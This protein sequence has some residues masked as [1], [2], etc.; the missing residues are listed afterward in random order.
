LLSREAVDWNFGR[1]EAIIGENGADQGEVGGLLR[2][3]QGRCLAEAKL[4]SD[5]ADQRKVLFVLRNE[6]IRI[7]VTL[8]D[9]KGAILKVIA[10]FK[11]SRRGSRDLGIHI[12]ASQQLRR[13]Q[14]EKSPSKRFHLQR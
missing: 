5:A 13:D 14:P 10:T 12:D 9:V 6:A 3:R 2:S 7:Q 4:C 1:E 8:E 11:E